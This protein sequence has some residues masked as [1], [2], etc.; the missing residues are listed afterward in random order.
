ME[1]GSNTAQTPEEAL[2]NAMKGRDNLL[3]QFGKLAGGINNAE[4]LKDKVA[5]GQLIIDGT[6]ALSS[7]GK[8]LTLAGVRKNFRM[9]SGERDFDRYGY[10]LR[11]AFTR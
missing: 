8:S 6:T 7:N 10:G 4:L 9:N 11:G 2:N 5:S 1:L 3:A